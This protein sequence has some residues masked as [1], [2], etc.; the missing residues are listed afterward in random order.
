MMVDVT[1]Q[2]V[3]ST[4]QT[5]GILVGIVY[6]VMNLNY[7]RKNQEQTLL[8]R[9]TTLF[10]QTIGSLINSSYGIKN[11]SILNQNKPQSFEEHVELTKK[12][13]E[14]LEAWLWIINTLDI[15]GI[16][17]KEGVLDIGM[18]AKYVPWWWR[19]FWDQYKPIVYEWRKIHGPSYMANMEHLMDSLQEYFEEYPERAP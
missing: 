14:Y 10:Q 4:V 16:Y 17:L 8:T 12:H 13:P 15:C 9:K 7:T 18:F 5:A 2:M 11:I 3:L 19:E 1:Y 6:Y